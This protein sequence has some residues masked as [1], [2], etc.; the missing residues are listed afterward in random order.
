MEGPF[1]YF[2]H[3]R[4]PRGPRVQLLSHKSDRDAIADIPSR[5][6][7][8]SHNHRTLSKDTHTHIHKEPITEPWY[9]GP[10]LF[11]SEKLLW[12]CETSL[13]EPDIINQFYLINDAYI[14]SPYTVCLCVNVKLWIPAWYIGLEIGNSI[15]ELQRFCISLAQ[16]FDE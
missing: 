7:N 15:R 14:M 6:F 16:T 13:I 3:A 10:W 11:V 12:N 8:Q 2:A 1:L 5:P 9:F 4:G